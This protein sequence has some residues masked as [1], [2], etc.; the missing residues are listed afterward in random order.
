[1]CAGAISLARVPRVVYAASDPRS[2]ALG[3]VVNLYAPP[4]AV[5]LN[6]LPEVEAGVLGEEAG[7][8]PRLFAQRRSRPPG[9]GPLS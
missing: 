8:A 7:D 3:G 2:G 5:V 4:I 6:H 1:M 9:E